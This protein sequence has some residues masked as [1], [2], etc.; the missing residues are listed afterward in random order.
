MPAATECALYLLLQ[1]FC[2]CCDAVLL[3]GAQ[4]VQQLLCGG[5]LCLDKLVLTLQQLVVL[6]H[7]VS[8]LLLV[9]YLVLNALV[10]AGTAQA[11]TQQ[12]PSTKAGPD[13]QRPCRHAP[14]VAEGMHTNASMKCMTT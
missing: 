13:N 6:Q 2:Q 9:I 4:L 1:L 3:C 8:L 5:E 10:Q 7:L 14:S 11:K 12:H